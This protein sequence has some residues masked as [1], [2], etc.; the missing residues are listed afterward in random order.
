M[1]SRLDRRGGEG[2]NITGHHEI[3]IEMGDDVHDGDQRG[4]KSLVNC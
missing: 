1:D 3:R 2:E 4:V